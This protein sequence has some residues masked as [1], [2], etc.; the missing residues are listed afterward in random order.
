VGGRV[1]SRV[2]GE[3]GHCEG[4]KATKRNF[5]HDVCHGCLECRS[6]VLTHVEDRLQRGNSLRSWKPREQDPEDQQVLRQ[7]GKRESKHSNGL[8]GP[9]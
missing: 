8:V 6:E 5:C 3:Q 4:K 7:E 2:S 9:T 1:F